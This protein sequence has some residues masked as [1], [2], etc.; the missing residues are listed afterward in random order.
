MSQNKIKFVNKNGQY[1]DES[2]IMSFLNNSLLGS[3]LK[4]Q[5]DEYFIMVENREQMSKNDYTSVFL[6][7]TLF[8]D[9]QN[10]YHYQTIARASTDE[11]YKGNNPE[12][13]YL[14][15]LCVEESFRDQGIG[16]AILQF[17]Q[18]LAAERGY[19]EF[20]LNAT[21]RLR[22]HKLY[23]NSNVD[24][25]EC[26]YMKNGFIPYEFRDENCPSTKFIRDVRESDKNKNQTKEY[27]TELINGLTPEEDICSL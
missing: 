7:Y 4:T 20:R 10:Q 27:E 17:L 16:S 18:S 8:K 2:M 14:A 11:M 3:I 21:A 9:Q 6:C 13:F 5:N 12:T 26:F 24:A 1:A 23:P 15:T 22:P 25:N 19:N